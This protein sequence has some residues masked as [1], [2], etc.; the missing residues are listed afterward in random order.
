MNLN[1]CAHIFVIV[2]KLLDF[3][4]SS[5]IEILSVVSTKLLDIRSNQ[6]SSATASKCTQLSKKDHQNFSGVKTNF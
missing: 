2:C 3:L 1:V 6:N 5:R 4:N